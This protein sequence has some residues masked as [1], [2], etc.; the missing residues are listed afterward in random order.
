LADF[1]NHKELDSLPVRIVAASVESAEDTAALSEKLD[2]ENIEMVS[3]LDAEAV[4][5][6]TGAYVDTSDTPF[7]QPTAFVL[8]SDGQVVMSV[9]SSAARGRLTPD[10]VVEL[11]KPAIDD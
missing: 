4:R 6:A 1:Q 11:V 8:D 3:D 2:L 9:F 10:D 5:A 7:L